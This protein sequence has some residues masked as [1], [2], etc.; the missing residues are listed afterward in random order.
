VNGDSHWRYR[1]STLL[2]SIA[3]LELPERVTEAMHAID[4]RKR[5]AECMADIALDDCSG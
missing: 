4:T 5:M 3:D 1:A 2:R